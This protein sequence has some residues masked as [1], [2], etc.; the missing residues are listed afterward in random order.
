MN[1]T[2]SVVYTVLAILAFLGIGTY[3]L[4]S[5]NIRREE[6]LARAESDLAKIADEVSDALTG[7]QGTE[8][9]LSQTIARYRH[10]RGLLVLSDEGL[11]Y[12]YA[13]DRGLI[14]GDGR[15]IV[16][17]RRL[18]AESLRDAVVNAEEASLSFTAVFRLLDDR[19][20]FRLLRDALVMVLGV[21]LLVVLFLIVA[22]VKRR[23]VES[24]VGSGEQA[25]A[26][27]KSTGAQAAASTRDRGSH[28]PEFLRPVA[29]DLDTAGAELPPGPPRR[30]GSPEAGETTVG[31][32]AAGETATDADETPADETSPEGEGSRGA[33]RSGATAP[34]EAPRG[35]TADSADPGIA[36]ADGVG[37]LFSPR[38]GLS[39]RHHLFHRLEQEIQRAAF[40]EEDLTV[41]LLSF[42]GLMATDVEY[43]E[44]A[45]GLLET[46]RFAELIF[47]FT[48]DEFCVILPN[49]NLEDGIRRVGDFLRRYPQIASH[50]GLSSRNGRL[51]EAERLLG[52]AQRA[53]R[54]AEQESSVT[55]GFRS[56]PDLYRSFLS[57]TKDG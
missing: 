5:L 4:L 29:R 44:I 36:A 41:A 49:T 24:F 34:K 19:V 57:K 9:S 40:N 17:V 42:P 26:S 21:A 25:Y 39:Y 55:M 37:E 32:A 30:T 28:S 48:D 38:T 56:D 10:L 53:R 11:E 45:E 22:A 12:L 13:T 33:T 43:G 46:F 47:E 27:V 52:E 23:Q 7:S 51:V 6:A 16:D 3:V 54:K 18:E 2:W 35:A 50:G 31:G 8:E 1:K 20:V 15:R 14:A